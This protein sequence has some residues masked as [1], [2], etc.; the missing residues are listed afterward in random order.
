MNVHDLCRTSSHIQRS[1]YRVLCCVVVVLRFIVGNQS[2]L[3]IDHAMQKVGSHSTIKSLHFST[4]C[5]YILSIQTKDKLRFFHQPL[6][7]SIVNGFLF[8]VFKQSHASRCLIKD[9]GGLMKFRRDDCGGILKQRHQMFC[10]LRMV[11]RLSFLFRLQSTKR[12]KRNVD[13]RRPTANTLSLS[14]TICRRSF[15]SSSHGCRILFLFQFFDKL[16]YVQP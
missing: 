10:N 14:T 4:Q 7:E 2:K 11:E 5:S 9:F 13:T 8:R 15:F 16:K 3:S 12:G 1:H 6:I